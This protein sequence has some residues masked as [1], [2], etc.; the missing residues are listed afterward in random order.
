[1]ADVKTKRLH[2]IAATLRTLDAESADLRLLETMLG[3][4]V[5][6]EWPPPLND[7]DSRQF[8]LAC[9]RNDA[10]NSDWVAWYIVRDE[11]PTPR[12]VIGN[13][14]FK[15]A[16]SADGGVEIGYS[17]FPEFQQHGYATEAVSALLKWAFAHRG[18]QYVIAETL[19]DLH[20]S[21]AV[22]TRTGFTRVRESSEPGV[23]RFKKSRP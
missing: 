3:A 6:A 17:L 1:M 10:A 16:P 7:E 21:I 11:A 14:G 22:L 4:R 20:P 15:G 19:P 5:P 12:I 23:I 8:W 9:L 13:C 18:V 2:L